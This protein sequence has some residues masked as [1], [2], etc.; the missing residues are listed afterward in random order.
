MVLDTAI[1]GHGHLTGG[2]DWSDQEPS[3]LGIS[4]PPG[5]MFRN[6]QRNAEPPTTIRIGPPEIITNEC[7]P[8]SA[9]GGL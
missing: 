5:P 9:R 6:Q 7:L 3:L 4:I 2:C 8:N 1:E